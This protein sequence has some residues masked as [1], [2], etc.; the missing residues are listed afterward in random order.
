[1]SS[2]NLKRRLALSAMVVATLAGCASTP[3]PV[4]VADTLANTPNLSTLN[5]LV[6]SAGLVD[7]LKGPGPFTVFAPNNEAFG[8]VPAATMDAL[9][10]D[11]A[12]LRDVLT[13]H[14][15]PGKTMAGD[16]KVNSTVKT[17]NGA[18]A[19]ISKAGTFVTIE[20]ALVTTADVDA[21]NGVIH[22]IDTVNIPPV[23]R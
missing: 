7:T 17:V 6:V 3:T 8:K 20:D 18:N 23:R 10:K 5:R 11:P 14:V 12:R 1:M 9:G 16:V 15:V 19:V 21:T 13:F 2:F 4:S 22:V